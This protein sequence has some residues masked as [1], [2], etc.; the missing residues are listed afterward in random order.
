MHFRSEVLFLISWSRLIGILNEDLNSFSHPAPPSFSPSSPLSHTPPLSPTFIPFTPD[1][2]VNAAT[3]RKEHSSPRKRLKLTYAILMVRSRRNGINPRCY[4]H[5]RE[6][7]CPP[8]F[9]YTI[10]LKKAL[11]DPCARPERLPEVAGHPAKPLESGSR[12]KLRV[13]KRATWS[14]EFRIAGINGG[15]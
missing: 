11:G 14:L 2:K 5:P 9:S 10:H 4:I 13:E 7:P 6:P 1:W 15:G 8:K 3:K 12:Q